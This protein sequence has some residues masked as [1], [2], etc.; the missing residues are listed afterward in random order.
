MAHCG[1][2]IGFRDRAV[3]WY[4][5]SVA[6][7]VAGQHA[8]D[9]QV[10]VFELACSVSAGCGCIDRRTTTVRIV[11]DLQI[12]VSCIVVVL[13]TGRQCSTCEKRVTFNP[14]AESGRCSDVTTDYF[15]GEVMGLPSPPGVVGHSLVTIG[16]YDFL[17]PCAARLICP[18]LE[19]PGVL[20][21]GGETGPC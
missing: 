17:P 7:L 16:Q 9:R 11:N 18:P 6:L 14:Q 20:C 2:F 13:L 1:A 12:G 19:C 21:C 10:C 8:G 3:G 4:S 5:R 15:G